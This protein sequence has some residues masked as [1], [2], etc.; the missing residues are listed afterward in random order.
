MARVTI[1][2]PDH[3]SEVRRVLP[4]PRLSLGGAKPMNLT[5]IDNGKPNAR[6]LL[7]YLADELTSRLPLATTDMHSKP[8][9]GKPI[10]ADVA[11]MLAARS[12]LAISGVGD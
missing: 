1:V 8:S 6:R 2:R 5:L 12:H 3:L 11:D 10:D 7:G 9:A 4:A